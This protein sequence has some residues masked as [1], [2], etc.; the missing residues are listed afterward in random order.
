MSENAKV[1][2]P[3]CDDPLTPYPGL[4]R[5]RFMHTVGGG[6]AAL[7]VGAPAIA[8]A[9]PGS[10][11]ATTTSRLAK[12]AENLIHELFRSMSAEQRSQVVQPWN[13]GAGGNQ[14]A[15]RLRMYNAA[16]GRTI[17]QV[18]TRPQ[19]EIIHRI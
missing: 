11:P 13:H 19:Q 9:Q 7:L 2:C 1:I 4:D 12:P 15:S 3:E 5:R 18:Y 14:L 8:Q 6:A 16:I 10:A 17:S